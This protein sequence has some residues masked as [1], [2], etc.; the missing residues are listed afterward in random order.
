MLLQPPDD[1]LADDIVKKTGVSHIE[2]QRVRRSQGLL[3][4]VGADRV[5]VKLA[6]SLLEMKLN[7]ETEL[8]AIRSRS[9]ALKAD[10]EAVAVEEA[11]GLR[12][13][14]TIPSEV[15][16][17]AIGKAGAY[18]TKVMALDGIE[19]VNIDKDREPPVVRIRGR[20][21]DA[22]KAARSMLEFAVVNV[23]VRTSQIPWI[24]GRDSQTVM[25]IK[26]K[27]RVRA[28]FPCTHALII[29]RSS[30]THCGVTRLR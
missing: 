30:H 4:I 1:T 26:A 28:C 11:M 25:G 18:V 6:G 5:K 7:Q 8:L 14:F 2:Y 24:V 29:S 22:V 17:L 9:S 16:G 21:A 19:T 10:L 12:C 3:V 15:L 13:E 20:T 23:P 27:S